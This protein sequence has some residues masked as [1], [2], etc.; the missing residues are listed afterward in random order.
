MLLDMLQLTGQLP[1]IKDYL[2]QNVN[3]PEAEKPRCGQ[4]DR[5]L[6]SPRSCPG[7]CPRTQSL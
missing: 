1:K 2:V 3:S 5:S 6:I 4:Q 7:R